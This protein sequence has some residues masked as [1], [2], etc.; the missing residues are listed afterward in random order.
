MVKFIYGLIQK[1]GASVIWGEPLD[2][3]LLC[4]SS[5]E[6]AKIP[7]HKELMAEDTQVKMNM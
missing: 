5:E 3:L 4:S 2:P 1:K 7:I 6:L